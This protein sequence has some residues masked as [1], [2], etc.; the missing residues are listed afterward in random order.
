MEQL[1]PLDTAFLNLETGN[2]P[3]HVGS[4][5]I[6]D[7]STVDGAVLG[8]KE[9]IK[10]FESRLHKVPSLRY[11][12]VE[13][14]MGL[15]YPYWIADPDFDIEFHLRH[16]AL[17]QPGD[18]RQLCIQVARIHSRPLDMGR[19]PWEIYV[20]E[21]LDNIDGL[22]QGCFG[23]V[24]KVHHSLVD[25]VFG[26]QLLTALHDLGPKTSPIKVDKPWI[27]DRVPTGVELLSR[28]A[29]NGVRNFTKKGKALSQHVLPGGV[30]LA[31][32]LIKGKPDQDSGNMLFKAPKTRFN[33]Q[34]SAHRVFE[35]VDF[36]LKDIK[37]LK[38]TKAGVSLND[39]MVGIVAGALRRY[40]RTKGELPEESLTAMLP[41][42]VRPQDRSNVQGNQISFMFP[43]VYT[44]IEDP[45]ERLDAIHAAT[46][47]GK[48][49]NDKKGGSL[50]LD[51]AQLLPTTVTNAAL[52]T[53]LKYNLTNY[54]KPLFNTVITNV[55]GPQLPLY[56]A[57]AKLVNF[58]GTGISYDTMGLFHILFSYN[59]KI[60]ISVTCCRSMMPDPAFYADCLRYSM[61]EMQ[62]ALLPKEELAAKK[63]AASRRVTRKVSADIAK[64][65]VAEEKVVEPVAVKATEEKPAPTKKPVHK[66][67]TG[68]RK[69]AAR[70]TT[71]RK[72]PAKKPN[73]A[74]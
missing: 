20:I 26:A 41:I 53:A 18:W 35:A 55:P 2:T 47:K 48:S 1:S 31:R 30:D 23:V 51:V 50:M 65:A 71:T 21:G 7:Q 9:I 39:V 72:A 73:S 67:A 28:A 6:Y 11:R 49:A 29:F 15:D 56:F 70:K 52:R 4:L 24:T 14:P 62:K 33:D 16:I 8:F 40:L 63:E 37:A 45:S 38:N 42:S 17:P 5:G 64:K 13:V 19:P 22:P 36:D 60:S 58:Y 43:K 12:M 34:V 25:G 69:P 74:S 66:T 61:K 10:F 68:T 46:S 32:N 44:D 59:G 27:V 3:M 54:L 57:G